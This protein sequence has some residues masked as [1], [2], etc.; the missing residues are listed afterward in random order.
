MWFTSQAE[1]VTAA[2]EFIRTEMDYEGHIKIGSSLGPAQSSVNPSVR[3]L[4]PVSPS[5][6]ELRP[7]GKFWARI[8]A[9]L[10]GKSEQRS[11]REGI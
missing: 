5:V 7:K 3:E 9:V 6:R 8:R 2:M 10:L 1:F 4:R 11:P